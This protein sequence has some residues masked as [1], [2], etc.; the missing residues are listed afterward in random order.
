MKYITAANNASEAS[1]FR[2]SLRSD[3]MNAVYMKFRRALKL[4]FCHYG[5]HGTKMS[6]VTS[7]TCNEFISMVK[8]SCITNGA[9][10]IS[11][12]KSI[13]A[14]VQEIEGDNLEPEI[15]YTEFQEILACISLYKDPNP[16]IPMSKKASLFI[17]KDILPHLVSKVKGLSRVPL[18]II[19]DD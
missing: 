4:I 6:Y 10:P 3:E 18:G 19:S 15:V 14:Q 17:S 5:S 1:A 8:D 7:M 11:T 2:K 9:F 13:I 16:F 12:V